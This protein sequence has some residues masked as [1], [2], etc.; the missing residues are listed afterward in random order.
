MNDLKTL[1]DFVL[2]LLRT[3]I[4]LYGFTFSF[5]SVIVWS[6]VATVCLFIIGKI[7]NS[8]GGE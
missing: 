1:F 4:T 2:D 5:W 3:P 8:G 7:F 6:L